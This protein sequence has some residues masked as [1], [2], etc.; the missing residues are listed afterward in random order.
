MIEPRLGI[1]GRIAQRRDGVV[2]LHEGLFA[3]VTQ[4]IQRCAQLLP[5]LVRGC[6]V[7]GACLKRLIGEHPFLLQPGELFLHGADAACDFVQRANLGAQVRQALL[8]P[9]GF[10]QRG[11]ARGF[12]V[13]LTLHQ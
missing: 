11:L 12:G 6:I 1:H 5:A 13:A 8:G 9:L 4:R 10:V 7:V 3:L 2:Q